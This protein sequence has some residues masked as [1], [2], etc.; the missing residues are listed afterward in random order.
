MSQNR[1]PWSWSL[2]FLSQ[3]I[4]LLGLSTRLHPFIPRWLFLVAF[5]SICVYLVG[6]TAFRSPV[7]NY[8]MGGYLFTVFF[9]AMDFLVL[10]D[11]QKEIRMEGQK[12]GE[13]EN[14]PFIKRLKWSLGLIMSQRSL[15]WIDPSA[16]K[17]PHIPFAPTQGRKALVLAKLRELA[18]NLII[19]DL[20][21]ILNRAN[22]CFKRDGPP[23][24][25]GGTIASFLWR[26]EL[27]LGF[28]VGEYLVLTT[29]HCVYCIVSVGFGLS[30]PRHWPSLFGS[31][32]EAYTI[33]RLWG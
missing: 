12:L 11:A 22:P 19:F 20:V 27:T 24:G 17:V 29:M 4:Y 1:R 8:G 23:V 26:L 21:G 33:R 6:Y 14:E 16:P 25:E 32:W 28:A 7:D 3:L 2:Y 15:G 31:V 5:A 18:F 30:E 10:R 13:I 9:D